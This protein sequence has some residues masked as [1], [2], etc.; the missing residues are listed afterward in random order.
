[1]E[2]DSALSALRKAQAAKQAE[3]ARAGVATKDAARARAEVSCRGLPSTSA[4]CQLLTL[5]E[6]G[7]ATAS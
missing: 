2:L 6:L 7:L 3:Q 5:L 4:S 1:M